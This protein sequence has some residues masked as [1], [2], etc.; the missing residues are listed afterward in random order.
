MPHL[1]WDR[2]APSTVSACLDTAEMPAMQF[3]H[4]I[5]YMPDPTEWSSAVRIRITI[6]IHINVQKVNLDGG[7]TNAQDHKLPLTTRA[8]GIRGLSYL[9]ACWWNWTSPDRPLG[10]STENAGVESAGRHVYNNIRCT[11]LTFQASSVTVVKVTLL[12]YSNQHF[13]AS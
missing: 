12:M 13:I 1:R 6:D 4:Q 8:V 5:Q 10:G 3:V 7:L 11:W 2:R 9:A